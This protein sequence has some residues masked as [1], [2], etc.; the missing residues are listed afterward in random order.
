MCASIT[1]GSVVCGETFVGH[2]VV[3]MGSQATEVGSHGNGFHLLKAPALVDPSVFE[4]LSHVP[5]GY[6]FSHRLETHLDTIPRCLHKVLL[7]STCIY[8][9]CKG[10][11]L[12][13]FTLPAWKLF[14]M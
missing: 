8:R 12:Q 9:Q 4:R 1:R 14:S 3:C 2:A 6:M 10:I 5:E 11:N 13:G 7:K